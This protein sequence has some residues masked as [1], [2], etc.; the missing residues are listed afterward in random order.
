[1]SDREL[2][3]KLVPTIRAWP[4]EP[5]ALQILEVLD[6]AIHGSLASGFV[7]GALQVMY[8]MALKAENTT[9]EEVIKGA[10]WRD[11]Q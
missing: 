7:V 3:P 4:D 2:D 6:P 5:S 9:H 1:M 11:H 8:D 10:S